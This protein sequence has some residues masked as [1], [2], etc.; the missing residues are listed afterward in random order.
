MGAPDVRL[1]QVCGVRAVA[2]L[3]GAEDAFVFLHQPIW[4]KATVQAA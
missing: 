3:D 2:R 4:G 1:A